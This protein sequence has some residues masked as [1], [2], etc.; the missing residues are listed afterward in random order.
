MTDD[1][2]ISVGLTGHHKTRK[3]KRRLGPGGCWSLVVLFLWVGSQRWDGTLYGMT[4]EDI[5][6]ASDWDGEPGVFVDALLAIGFLDG[7]PGLRAIHDWKDHNPYAASKGERI[8][9]GKQAAAA[10]WNGRKSKGSHAT[11]MPT[12]CHEHATTI[13]EQCPPA[14]APTPT[15]KAKAV[16]QPDGCPHQQIVDLYHDLLPAN[17]RIKDWTGKRQANLRSRWREDPRRQ[18]LDYWERFLR[19]VAASPFL[20]GQRTGSNGRPFLPGLDWLVL[21]ENFA[22]VIEGR[23]HEREIAA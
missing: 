22:K 17:P 13:A 19:H 20:T 7:E 23:Y 11:S 14:P 18:S 8:E 10:R 5:E 21:P 16:S 15:V 2:R 4:D 1:V 6:L 12:A 9:K 3:L